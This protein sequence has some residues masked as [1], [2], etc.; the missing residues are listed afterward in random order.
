[1]TN[2]ALRTLTTEAELAALAPQWDALVTAAPRPSPFMLHAWLL[3]WWR[4]FGEGS[5]LEVHA[6]FRD[7][8]LVGA[9]P[10]FTRRERGLRIT[11]FVGGGASALGDVLVAPGADVDAVA[12]GL[13]SRAA[14]VKH[15]LVDVFG[16]PAESRLAEA[17]G[18][19]LRLLERVE[20]PVLDL[21]PG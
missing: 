10:L 8:R 5:S 6:A 20:A 18:E 19:G 14:T 16:L 11:A 4:H 7:G 12:R 3:V 15:D 21:G 9:L 17:A 13:A 2:L 1:M